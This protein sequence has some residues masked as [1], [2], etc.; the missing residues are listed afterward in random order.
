MWHC[1]AAFRGYPVD[2]EKTYQPGDIV[3]EAEA[4]AMA[5]ISKPDLAEWKE[6]TVD[7]QN[8]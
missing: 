8:P 2:V 3:P 1:I 7:P 6:E 4:E 5:L